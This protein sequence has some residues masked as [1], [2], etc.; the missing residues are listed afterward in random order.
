MSGML[1]TE[2]QKETLLELNKTSYG[3]QS[4]LYRSK[5]WVLLKKKK[6][7]AKE[8]TVFLTVVAG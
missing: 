7:R 5:Y 4:L 2:S 3:S 6:N 8:A 1:Q